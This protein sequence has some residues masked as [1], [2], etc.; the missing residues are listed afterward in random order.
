M[1]NNKVREL[2]EDEGIS[3]AELA[4]LSGVSEKTLRDVEKKRRTPAP[5][6]KGKIAK[7]FN[8]IADKKQLYTVELL[9]Q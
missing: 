9:F 3:M 2:R 7:G 4:R 8:K 5:F 6:T 1:A